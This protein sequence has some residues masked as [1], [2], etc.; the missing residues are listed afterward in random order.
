MGIWKKMAGLVL[1]AVVLL[2]L[3]FAAGQASAAPKKKAYQ[4]IDAKALI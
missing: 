1:A 4:P 3:G 2:G